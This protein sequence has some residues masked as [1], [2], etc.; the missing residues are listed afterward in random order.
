MK[1][2]TL[3][4]PMAFQT[5]FCFM[6]TKPNDCKFCS[7]PSWSSSKINTFWLF[8]FKKTTC[9]R[10]LWIM[11]HFLKHSNLWIR[12]GSHMQ[13]VCIMTQNFMTIF[14]PTNLFR[15]R[16]I[17]S[18]NYSRMLYFNY[19]SATWSGSKDLIGFNFL[20]FNSHGT[21]NLL[22]AVILIF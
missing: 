3:Q 5:P 19:H 21:K 17:N 6:D 15:L 10:E 12:Y 16:R 13:Y 18:R 2:V 22:T 1:S 9:G 11:A 8:K 7:S 4:G 20:F 14:L